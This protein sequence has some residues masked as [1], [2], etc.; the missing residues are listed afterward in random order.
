M[1]WMAVAML[2]G[3]A[4]P[5]TAQELTDGRVVTKL[6]ISESAIE[7]ALARE[8]AASAMRQQRDSLK[9]GV[10]IGALVGFAIGAVGGKLLCAAFEEG[11]TPCWDGVLRVGALGAA[12]GAG[13]G[14]GIDALAYR[15]TPLPA[16]PAR[17]AMDVSRNLLRVRF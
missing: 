4:A 16:L 6:V 2:L 12:I 13:A 9:N 10:I 11:H 3:V 8:R 17:R 1:C 5:T 7:M 15:R 14:A